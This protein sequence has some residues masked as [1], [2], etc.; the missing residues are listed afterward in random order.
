[1]GNRVVT[2]GTRFQCVSEEIGKI[3]RSVICN[4]APHSL[5]KPRTEP[6]PLRQN[7]NSRGRQQ[8]VLL[9]DTLLEPLESG[10]F[11]VFFQGFLVL[12]SNK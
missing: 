12:V 4:I 1:M 8:E 2:H 6:S 7:I 5:S 10:T 11:A 3:K 9:G